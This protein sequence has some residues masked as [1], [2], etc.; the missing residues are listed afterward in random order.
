MDVGRVVLGRAGGVAVRVQDA[1]GAPVTANAVYL[2]R[3]PRILEAV[4]GTVD[5]PGPLDGAFLAGGLEGGTWTLRVRGRLFEEA[6]QRIEVVE[7]EDVVV[8]VVVRTGVRVTGVVRDE[9]GRPVAGASIE[10][11]GPAEPPATG[12]VVLRHA[13]ADR[14]G[15]FDVAMLREGPLAIRG[16]ATGLSTLG[17]GVAFEGARETFA[18][19]SRASDARASRS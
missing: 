1:G 14:E 16:S 4:F 17:D 2:E 6:T 9:D 18:S 19:C 3:G 13:T 12:T 8:T 10:I 7:G 11:V 5:G 15:A